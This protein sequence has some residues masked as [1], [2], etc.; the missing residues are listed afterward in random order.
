MTP[1]GAPQAATAALLDAL[2]RAAWRPQP[3][4]AM[5]GARRVGPEPLA[6]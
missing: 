6:A 3:A 5:I 2:R 4:V 1:T